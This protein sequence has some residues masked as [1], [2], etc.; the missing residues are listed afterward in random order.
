[1]NNY[2]LTI[3]LNSMVL[4]AVELNKDEITIGRDPFNDIVIDNP[5]I[6]R[7]HATIYKDNENYIIQDLESSNGTIINNFVIN[8]KILEVGDEIIIGKHIIKVNAPKPNGAVI[9]LAFQSESKYSGAAEGTLMVDEKGRRKFLDK[10]QNSKYKQL[11]FI[12]LED[13]RKVY[14]RDSYFVI[15]KE[16]G[17][18]VK[19]SG[20]FIKKVHAEITKINPGIYKLVS[21]G[22]FLSPVKINGK[23]IKE[24]IL[25]DGDLIHLANT[26]MVY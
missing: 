21:Y 25:E 10:I 23:T 19:V 2:L 5:A 12:V 4:D 13:N 3:T 9:D 17:S 7:F 22:N 15:G 1:M 8:R 20:F 11:P 16:K 24:K 14:I 6:S 26:W 18:N